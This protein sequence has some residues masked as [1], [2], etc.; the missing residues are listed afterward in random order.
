MEYLVLLPFFPMGGGFFVLSPDFQ[1][2]GQAKI[3]SNFYKK[4]LATLFKFD[5]NEAHETFSEGVCK[6]A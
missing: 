1:A 2:S 6:H 4:K 5:Y 3:R